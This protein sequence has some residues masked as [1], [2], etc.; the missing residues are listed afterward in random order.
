MDEIIK[1]NVVSQ[2]TMIKNYAKFD[3][4]DITLASQIMGVQQKWFTFSNFLLACVS[5][6][7]LEYGKE[8]LQYIMRFVF[9]DNLLMGI[10]IFDMYVRGGRTR[11]ACKLLDKMRN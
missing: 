5:A 8:I 9:G 2:T 1:Q 3:Y 6:V 11:Y 10:A 4:H 7:A